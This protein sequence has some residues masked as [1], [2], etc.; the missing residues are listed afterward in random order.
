M[1]LCSTIS[2]LLLN[3]WLWIY[4]FVEYQRADDLG[5]VSPV[6]GDEGSL[7]LDRPMLMVVFSGKYFR[8]VAKSLVHT[9][10]Y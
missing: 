10:S 7:Q 1:F 6:S 4:L 8:Q 2:N 5:T 9:N 3:D